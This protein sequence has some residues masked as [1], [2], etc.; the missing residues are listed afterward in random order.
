M[1]PAHGKLRGKNQL[2]M[3]TFLFLFSVSP[4]FCI[5]IHIWRKSVEK[6]TCLHYNFRF[7][8]SNCPSKFPVPRVM[9]LRFPLP[10]PPIPL[11][12]PFSYSIFHFPFPIRC[13]LAWWRF[14]FHCRPFH[15]LATSRL[16]VVLIVL[17]VLPVPPVLVPVHQVV[18]APACPGVFPMLKLYTYLQ[19]MS[20]FGQSHRRSCSCGCSWH[21]SLLF[22]V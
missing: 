4:G 13:L 15:S 10:L 7:S 14:L 17:D 11:P 12:L 9:L 5:F 20:S 16:P 1:L 22:A 21:A 18:L 6:G 2:E 19:V 8:Q 3:T